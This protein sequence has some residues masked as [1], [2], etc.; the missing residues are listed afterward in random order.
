MQM[1]G[2]APGIVYLEVAA[3][4]VVYEVG[5]RLLTAQGLIASEAGAALWLQGPEGHWKQGCGARILNVKLSTSNRLRPQAC[6]GLD[7]SR[8]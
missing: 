7:R 6:T 2:K 4:G 8:Q 5:H 1:L 3:V